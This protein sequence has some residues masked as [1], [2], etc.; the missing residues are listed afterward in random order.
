MRTLLPV[1]IVALLLTSSVLAGRKSS[2][3]LRLELLEEK[4]ANLERQLESREAC[5]ASVD[6]FGEAVLLDL[7]ETRESL[8][9]VRRKLFGPA[10]AFGGPRLNASMGWV[11][12][13]RICSGDL[14]P[15]LSPDAG[16][17]APFLHP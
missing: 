8:D 9:E 1:A 15:Q 16:G 3:D 5:D 11:L 14:A 10:A 12:M 13:S 7:R 6:S 17:P 2:S 4:V